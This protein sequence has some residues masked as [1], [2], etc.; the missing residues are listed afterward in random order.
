MESDSRLLRTG[1]RYAA[2]LFAA[3]MLA[4]TASYVFVMG[5]DFRYYVEYLVLAWKFRAFELPGFSWFFSLVGFVP[6]AILVVALLRRHA[7]H[8][9]R[10]VANASDE[11]TPTI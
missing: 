11:I 8:T 7:R 2:A 1:S 6:L 3:Y 5:S 9:N 10:F 4:W